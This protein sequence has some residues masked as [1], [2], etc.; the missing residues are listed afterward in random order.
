MRSMYSISARQHIRSISIA[1]VTLLLSA[2]MVSS[3]AS[4]QLDTEQDSSASA[5]LRIDQFHWRSQS[6]SA[7]WQISDSSAEAAL[8]L[9]S[10]TTGSLRITP[11][12][13]SPNRLFKYRQIELSLK[14]AKSRFGQA[15]PEQILFCGIP[16][17]SLGKFRLKWNASMSIKIPTQKLPETCQAD[18]ELIF[19]LKAFDQPVSITI[20]NITFF[21]TP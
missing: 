14:L 20:S 7:L 8:S 3:G 21:V 10:R 13:L 11:V 2:C 5:S 16:L 1:M 6:S 17:S 15:K 18:L 9:G 4:Q 12:N 19:Q